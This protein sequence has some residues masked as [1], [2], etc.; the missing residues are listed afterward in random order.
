MAWHQSVTKPSP[1]PLM[2]KAP[3]TIS[4]YERQVPT[5]LPTC[6][7]FVYFVH[8]NDQYEIYTPYTGICTHEIEFEF[9]LEFEVLP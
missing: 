3:G 8:K 9:L 7:H 4:W 6:T 2:T 5:E 1:E